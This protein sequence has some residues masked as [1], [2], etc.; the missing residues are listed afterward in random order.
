MTCLR[1]IRATIVVMA[2]ILA[3]NAAI[4]P[5]AIAARGDKE[6]SEEYFRDAMKYLKDGDANAAVIQLKNALQKDGNHV[7]A[8]KL[9][10]E[11]YLRVGNGPAA[12]KE[13]KAARSRGVDNKEIQILIARAYVLQGKFESVLKELEDDVADAALRADV[14]HVRGRA[15]LGLGMQEDAL[16]S[17]GEAEKLQPTDIR[18]MVGLAK[19]LI[20]MGK[21]KEA[22]QKADAA[23]AVDGSSVEALVLKGELSRL[24]QDLPGALAAFDKAIEANRT[25]IPALLGR[26][27]ALI[28]LNRDEE[29]QADIATVYSRVPKQPLAGY[30][31]ALV[32]AKKKDFAG[33]QE[34][35][36]QSAPML[37][38]HMPSVFLSGAIHYA[39]NQL[40]QAADLL[41]RY[42]ATVPGNERAR[43]LLG[44]TLVRKKDMAS[45]I[46]VLR[47]LLDSGKA[48]AQ[49]LALLGGA[50]MRT[51]KFAEG[52]ELFEQAVKMAPDV[53]SIRTQLA[54]SRL[55]QGAPDE[56]V[57]ELEAAIDLDPEA[58]QASILLT[59][60]HL[61][62]GRFDEA[63][64][65]A[66][67][68]REA[69]ADNPLAYNLIG[70]AWLGKG[71]VAEARKTFEK[72]LEIKA[73]FHPARMNLAQLD[74]RE[75][76][77]EGAIRHYEHILKE[78]PNHVG[79]LLA[80]AD[81]ATK[82]NREE[83]VVEWLR[84]ASDANPKAIGPK[85]R[86]IRHYSEQREFRRALAVARELDARVPNNAQVLEI[87]GRTEIAAGDRTGAVATFRRLV[88]VAGKAARAHHLL[89]GAL[90]AVN[91]QP[92]ARE[93]FRQAMSLDP[94]YVPAIMALA[95]LESRSGNLDEALKLATALS[96]AQPDSA[97]GPM[98]AGDAHVREKAYDKA[99][100]YYAEA[101]KRENSG[102][103]AL[104]I[105]NARQAAGQTV[106]A[107]SELQQ[108]VD[109]NDDSAVRHV[110][111]TNYI[112]NGYHDEA[113]KEA[114]KLMKVDGANPILLNNLA[115][116]YDQKGDDRAVA[117]AEKALAS[118]PNSPEIMDTLGW[119]VTRRGDIDRGVELLQAAHEAAPKQ[120]DIAYHFAVALSKQGKTV[121]ARRTLERILNARIDFSEAANARELLRKLGG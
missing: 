38:N 34:V 48:D 29:A 65:S 16:A 79:A 17:F 97:V 46:D 121:E 3:V 20:S 40:E 13:L 24:K 31:S 50:Y 39:L 4:S 8:R 100:A 32:L 49:V 111:T 118:A 72:A 67:K 57:G 90:V 6:A 89:G 74:L 112:A 71:E 41:A 11:I 58:R 104:R 101:L 76:N 105:F 78:D 53:S 64:E 75:N 12:E 25:S 102:V 43:K 70:A 110:L 28:D 37:D 30:L 92:A 56:A 96:A 119:L 120:G 1:L 77:V 63:L 22:E 114:E 10:G 108:W 88:G 81:V 55:V 109:S 116:L 83:D 80:L 107:L 62:K 59:L 27:A 69:M 2:T 60:V 113:I 73:D 91:D 44:A 68:L 106:K 95:E 5:P 7:G 98:L 45:A 14:L 26:A 66:E 42:V 52:A 51:G 23:L 87:L 82:Q 117:L 18:P 35:L 54:L 33:A 19:V 85:A 115:W 15:F 21:L 93:S 86:L 9:L 84:K 61:R 36:Q 47:P 103:L 99:L 94:K